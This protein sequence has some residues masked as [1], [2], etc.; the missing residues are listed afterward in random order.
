MSPDPHTDRQ[1]ATAAADTPASHLEISPRLRALMDYPKLRNA[2]PRMMV[3]ESGY[4][5]DAACLRAAAQ[6]G[7]Q[8]ASSPVTMKGTLPRDM[9]AALLNTLTHFKPD[10]LLSIN[11]AGMDEGGIFARLFS[12]LR[13]PYV[14]WFV[15]DPRT[16]IM[17]RRCYASE[18]S[19]AFSWDAA[20]LSYLNACGFTIAATLPLAADR[21]VFSE[22]EAISLAPPPPKAP[23]TPEV[24]FVG[25]S[26]TQPAA[27]EWRWLAEHP[28]AA[29]ALLEAFDS[30]RVTRENFGRGLQAILLE[31]NLSTWSEDELRHAEMYLFTEG[32]RRLR[33][34]MA[35]TLEGE[36]AWM[37]GD[38]A[39]K[40]TTS[41]WH[42][43]LDYAR[44]LPVHYRA[45]KVNLNVTSIQMP[46]AVN[47]RVF[48]CPAAGGF[49][50]TDAQPS[51]PQ[52]FQ[53]DS[54]VAIYANWEECT[55]KLRF[56]RDND[57]E[58]SAI[59]AAAQRRIEAEHRYEHRLRAIEQL[60]RAHFA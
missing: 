49:L 45:C 42:P 13:I 12:D 16:I 31:E 47:Q 11:L 39:W 14:T 55:E 51:L 60:L 7:W 27:E 4:W 56:Y 34:E 2:A 28:N 10:F 17:G 21:T 18:Y 41:L 37:Y 25:N 36:G 40:Q 46:T 8:T 53:P 24:A 43:P 3:L 29:I 15:D 23:L 5:L 19:V 59:I 26:M 33:A 44:E 35:R 58:R 9:I 48:D 30:D 1:K 52:L 6:L 22:T 57:R 38:E 32:T 20:Y 50:L 54:E